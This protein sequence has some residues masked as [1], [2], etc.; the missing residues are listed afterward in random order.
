MGRWWVGGLD[1]AGDE[2]EAERSRDCNGGGEGKVGAVDIFDGRVE[3]LVS[4]MS[5]IRQVVRKSS[6]CSQS[7]H[8]DPPLSHSILS[9][10][11]KLSKP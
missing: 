1:G 11:S 10:P 6:H 5:L 2:V 8:H 9:C 3:L 4:D 7:S